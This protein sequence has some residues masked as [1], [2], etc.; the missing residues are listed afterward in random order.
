MQIISDL[1]FDRIETVGQ[2]SRLRLVNETLET[3][4][5]GQQLLTT[6]NESG[7]VKETLTQTDVARILQSNSN[8]VDLV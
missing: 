4:L 8:S 6:T 1:Y 7:A 5:D 2:V 3:K